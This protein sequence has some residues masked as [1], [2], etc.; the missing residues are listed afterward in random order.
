MAWNILRDKNNNLF[1]LRNIDSLINSCLCKLFSGNGT[2]PTFHLSELLTRPEKNVTCDLWAWLSIEIPCTNSN[3]IKLT[4][5][6]NWWKIS[7]DLISHDYLMRAK[8]QPANDRHLQL[9]FPWL[10]RCF[11]KSAK[12]IHLLWIYFVVKA[13]ATALHFDDHHF[14]L[15]CRYKCAHRESK[16]GRFFSLFNCIICIKYAREC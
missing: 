9:I 15:K 11:C 3:I 14:H 12:I 1:T 5:L 8:K 16:I 4:A 13:F 2:I 6:I 7:I 10:I